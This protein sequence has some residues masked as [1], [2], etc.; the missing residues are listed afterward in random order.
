MSKQKFTNLK[1]KYVL[2]EKNILK[3][4][5][6]DFIDL[7]ALVQSNADVALDKVFDKFMSGEMP[8]HSYARPDTA[9][10]MFDSTGI[11]KDKFD[12][13]DNVIN[14]ANEV[15]KALL[16]RSNLTG[17]EQDRIINLSPQETLQEYGDY[18]VESTRVVS[19]ATQTEPLDT[20][21][22]GGQE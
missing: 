14:T 18:V 1:P 12:N 8:D 9:D 20:T 2:N 3:K 6:N 13:I 11:S 19:D 22:V 4:V 16:K 17:E 15:K 10:I 21:E 5:D 7:D